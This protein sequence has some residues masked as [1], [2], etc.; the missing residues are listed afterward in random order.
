MNPGG[1][2]SRRN[3]NF[4]LLH[5][6]VQL[7]YLTVLRNFEVPI[8]L[9][10]LESVFNTSLITSKQQS[11]MG[12]ATCLFF[13]CHFWAE[14]NY[15]SIVERLE[16]CIRP[17]VASTNKISSLRWPGSAYPAWRSTWLRFCHVFGAEVKGISKHDLLVLLCIPTPACS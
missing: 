13:L 15:A 11:L 14:G 12:S 7:E 5:Q 17:W 2:S 16:S 8:R 6:S 4:M 10:E 3:G 9:D 1:T